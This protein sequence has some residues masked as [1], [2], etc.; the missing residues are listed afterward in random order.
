MVVFGTLHLPASPG[1]EMPVGAPKWHE[2]RNGFSPL[3]CLRMHGGNEARSQPQLHRLVPNQYTV[4]STMVGDRPM[5]RFTVAAILFASIISSTLAAEP[6]FVPSYGYQPPV[7]SWTG[8]YVGADLGYGW[9]NVD[10]SFAING[11]N[12]ST[13]PSGFI[14]GIY[15][16]YNWQFGRIVAG[17]ETDMA[18]ANISD[19][20]DVFGKIGVVPFAIEA[21]DKLHWLGTTRARLGVLPLE[22]IMV[23]AS[24]GLA[25]GGI[26]EN[27]ISSIG[28]SSVQSS[29]AQSFSASDTRFGWAI[30]AGAE[31]ALSS[32][33]LVRAEWLHYDLGSTSNA[34]DAT[35]S[36]SGNI[37]RAGL[38]YKL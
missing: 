37:M 25:Y 16:G 9:A 32:N 2:V 10:H 14:G 34:F 5:K 7:W 31:W 3:E 21:E 4:Q 18:W 27:I 17:L 20:I 28:S 22:T 19:T 30:G 36:H 35:T 1:E 24:A 6:I 23:Y 8:F 33:F 11:L 29:F 12:V 26:E 13:K 15:A 38:S